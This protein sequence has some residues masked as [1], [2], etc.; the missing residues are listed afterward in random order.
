M[1][2]SVLKVGYSLKNITP[3][4]GIEIPGQQRIRIS[5]GI[6]A[7]LFVRILAI[8]NEEKRAVIVMC[9]AIRV[10]NKAYKE[11]QELLSNALQVDP[12]CVYIH[13]THT[14]TAVAMGA[15]AQ[16][17]EECGKECPIVAVSTA[18]PYKFAADVCR[19][20]NIDRLVKVNNIPTV[21]TLTAK[22]LLKAI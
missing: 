7:P 3:P 4:L 8:E 19:S 6:I 18:S 2:T 10:S 15:V 14:H 1:S 21:H 17:A 16:Y 13:A 5:E 12:D 20:L 11:L 22:T 9:D